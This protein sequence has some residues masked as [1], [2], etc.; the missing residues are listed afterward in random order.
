[1]EELQNIRWFSKGN[2]FAA[3]VSRLSVKIHV[4]NHHD[5]LIAQTVVLNSHLDQLIISFDSLEEAFTFVNSIVSNCS[6]LQEVEVACAEAYQ[7]KK[8][9]IKIKKE[10]N[11]E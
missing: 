10:K 3:S 1:M 5:K 4:H 6:T 8:P 11:P 9:K 7:G 2:G